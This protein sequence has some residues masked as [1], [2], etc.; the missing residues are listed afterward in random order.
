MSVQPHP[1][2][3]PGSDLRGLLKRWRSAWLAALMLCWTLL[4]AAQ[5]QELEEEGG[6]LPVAEA[7]AVLQRPLPDDRLPR[8][9][10]LDQQMHA[11]RQLAQRGLQVALAR[12]LVDEGRDHADW[13]TWLRAYL[14]AEFTWGEG[15]K[16]LEACEP[17]LADTSLPPALRAGVALRQTYMAA[18]EGDLAVTLNHWRR[19]QRLLAAWREG[20]RAPVEVAERQLGIDALQVR[21]E[22][23]RLQGRFEAA[24]ATLRE[25]LQEALAQQAD[26]LHERNGLSRHPDVQAFTGWVDG[27]RG[28]L[29]YALVRQGR[30][31]EALLLADTQLRRVRRGDLAEARGPRWLYRRAHALNALQRHEEALA[32]ADGSLAALQQSQVSASSH[33]GHL[34]LAERLRALMGLRRWAEADAAYQAHLAAVAGDR[35]ASARARNPALAAV[36]AAQAGRLDEALAGAERSLRYRERLFGVDHPSSQEMAGVRGFVRLARGDVDGAEADFERLFVAALDR[37]GGWLDLDQRGARGFVLGLVFDRYLRHV[38]SQAQGAAVTAPRR[39]ARALQIADRLKLGSTQ[40]AL[41]D[42]SSRLQAGHAPLREALEAEQ[43]ARAAQEERAE[44]LQALFAEEDAERRRMGSAAFKSLPLHERQAATEQLARLRERIR[45]AQAELQAARAALQQRRDRLAREHP[46]FADL[47]SPPLPAPEGLMQ[48]LRPGEALWVLHALEEGSLSWLLRP[49][50]PAQL[51]ALPLGSADLAQRVG[52]WRA[53][54]DRSARLQEPAAPALGADEAHELYRSLMAPWQ[55][56]LAGVNSLL[57]ASSGPLAGVP[58]AAL[59]REPLQAGRPPAWLLRDMAVSQLPSAASLLALRRQPPAA[60]PPRALIGFGDPLFAATASPTA[61]A[62]GAR[63]LAPAP[64][65]RALRWDEARGLRYGD[66]PPL[67]DTR[68]ELQAI[69]RS[70]G[71]DPRADLRL[72]AAATR[73]AVLAADLSDRR[74]V[75]FATHGLLP[76]ELPGL[77]K[78]ALALA[79]DGDASPLLELDDVLQ[80]RLRAH[81]VLL[82]ACNSA[83]AQQ[84]D[85][86]LSGLVRGFFF[87]GARS[88]LATHWAVESESAAA[89]SAAVFAR[90]APSRA[91]ALRRAQLQ[92]ADGAPKWRHPYFWAGYALF[93]DP[94]L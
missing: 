4:G 79:A 85:E 3:P 84:G 94:A 63:R 25:A 41:M 47:I 40:R 80:L 6:A 46:A 68:T 37:S 67:P 39:V 38:L 62:T 5:A 48:L 52:R 51:R 28:M 21:A 18:H 64:D 7:Q 55:A 8:L 73:A 50:Q 36:L 87:A 16:A 78:P 74:V 13:P 92:L 14:H 30:A 83:G 69:A 11:A 2:Q 10:L 27:S 42:A 65:A 34:A 57:V 23:E 90:A 89:L 81:W 19:A 35:L 53:Q 91:E 12:R 75:A 58:L 60:E 29:V 43:A 66:I 61:R 86:A 88:V 93:G 45:A 32:D 20:G 26:V 77:S 54:L 17:W 24:V 31:G 9:T 1:S 49:G 59:L 33:V 22:V 15:T 70:L 71:A 44:G 56:E 72:G 76:G 82:S